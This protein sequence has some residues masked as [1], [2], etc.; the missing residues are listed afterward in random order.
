MTVLQTVPPVQASESVA[1]HCLQAPPTHAGSGA[2]GHSG[3]APV[4]RSAL[5]AEQTLPVHTG[6]VDGHCEE[7]VQFT[8]V[9]VA[10]LQTEVAPV[11]ALV[12]PALHWTQ[13]PEARQAG[14]AA[15]HSKGV[16][17]GPKSPS[18]PTQLFVAGLQAPVAPLQEPGFVAVHST[19]PPLTQIGKPALGHA[20]APPA[21]KLPL[22]GPQPAASQMGRPGGQFADVTH[23]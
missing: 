12:L 8:H 16:V 4:T 22:Q 13:A 17:G 18:Q 23:V 11:Q 7:S 21:P 15:L 6:A 1:L 2:V 3:L 5:Q 19:Q 14:F 9:F 20:P 10:R